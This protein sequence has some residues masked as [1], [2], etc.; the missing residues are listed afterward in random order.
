MQLLLTC[1]SMHQLAIFGNPV[2]HSLSPQ[3]HQQFAAQFGLK[4]SYE[5]ILAPL[6]GFKKMAQDFFMQDGL[7]CNVTVPL[8]LEAFELVNELTDRAKEA[9]AVNT[10]KQQNRK[11]L[12][13]NTDG[14]GLIHD[15]RA[16]N[17]DIKNKKIIIIGA[18]GA[19]RGI[20]PVLMAQ[21]PAEIVIMN[22]DIEKAKMLVDW[23]EA[24]QKPSNS[25][26]AFASLSPSHL[27]DATL[28]ID[29]TS[30]FDAAQQFLTPL[31]LPKHLT[32]YDL[33]YGRE[34]PTPFIQWVQAQGLVGYDGLGMLIEQAVEAFYVWFS[35]RP[36]VT[37]VTV[38]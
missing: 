26:L 33:K 8:K 15:L 25:M 19:V 1:D 2:E 14:V 9:G 34:K 31:T 12:G 17:V 36:D 27:S 6:E 5:K 35:L 32:F 29:G 38:R 22:R 30:S 23:F 4:I 21:Q 18:G 28:F 24:Q 16:K 7:G 11:L 3:I 10:I 20:L 13:D 37:Q